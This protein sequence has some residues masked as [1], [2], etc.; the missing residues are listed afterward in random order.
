[1]IFVAVA[2]G[3]GL[4]RVG[5]SSARTATLHLRELEEEYA[6]EPEDEAGDDEDAAGALGAFLL[7]DLEKHNVDQGAGGEALKHGDRSCL[8]RKVLRRLRESEPDPGAN[9]RDEGERCYV[10]RGE[11]GADSRADELRPHAEGDDVLVRRDSKEE[12]P[13]SG[14]VRR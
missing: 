1:M 6:D 3:S 5:M 13:H 4:S 14:G 2:V 10:D 12:E 11:E 7:E 9:W 8:R